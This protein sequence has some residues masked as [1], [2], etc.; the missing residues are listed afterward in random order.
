MSLGRGQAQSRL[1]ADAPLPSGPFGYG[2]GYGYASKMAVT[3]SLFSGCGG[4]DLGAEWAGA[5]IEAAVERND[6]AAD[7]LDCRTAR[8]D[9]RR[10]RGAQGDRFGARPAVVRYRNSG[11]READRTR[12][13]RGRNL[14]KT[15]I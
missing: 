9:C 11:G 13:V 12:R 5:Q 7:S 3:V 14:V 2:Y 8:G 4:L 10:A 6:D 1:Q 15:A